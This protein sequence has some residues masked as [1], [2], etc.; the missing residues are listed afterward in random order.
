MEMSGMTGG[1]TGT[2][3][4]IGRAIAQGQVRNHGKQ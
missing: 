3:S 4:G 1:V 2:A